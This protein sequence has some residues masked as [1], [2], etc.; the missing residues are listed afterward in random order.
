VVGGDVGC[1]G[2]ELLE[3]GYEARVVEVG[4]MTWT[5]MMSLAAQAGTDVEPM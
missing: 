5:S 4:H 2:A 3:G 1:R